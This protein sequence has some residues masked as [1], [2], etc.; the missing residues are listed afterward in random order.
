MIC[1]NPY[2]SGVVFHPLYTLVMLYSIPKINGICLFWK[3][4]V[5]GWTN[6]FEQKMV[7]LDQQKYAK[8]PPNH[9][10]LKL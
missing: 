3:K 7:K 4:V 8:P 1:Y 5:G 9:G 10:L 6:P 2:I